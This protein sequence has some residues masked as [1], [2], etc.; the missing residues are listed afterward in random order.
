M[1]RTIIG[2]DRICVM[3]AGEI[4]ELDTPQALFE[5]TDSIFRSM[6]DRSGISLADIRAASKTREIEK[7]AV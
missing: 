6:C 4:A 1:I 5:Q 3:D 7:D 2:Y